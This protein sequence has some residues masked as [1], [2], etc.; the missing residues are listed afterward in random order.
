M[1]VRTGVR[2]DLGRE[3]QTR[4]RNE[5]DTTLPLGLGGHGVLKTR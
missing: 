3:D 2:G 4:R 1:K 5:E